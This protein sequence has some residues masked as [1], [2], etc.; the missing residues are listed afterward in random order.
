M[1]WVKKLLIKCII[2]I[3][4]KVSSFRLVYGPMCKWCRVLKCSFL[5]VFP[6]FFFFGVF[7]ENDHRCLC[8]PAHVPQ[9][10]PRLSNGHTAAGSQSPVILNVQS[11]SAQLGITFTFVHTFRCQG[12]TMQLPTNSSFLQ[13]TT[14]THARGW[15]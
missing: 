12:L 6:F 1:Y 14:H 15:D 10:V 3:F 7:R 5:F 11:L 2:F 4:Q 13:T 9:L 8:A